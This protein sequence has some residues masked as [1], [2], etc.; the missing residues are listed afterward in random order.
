MS[1][2]QTQKNAL[3]SF[4]QAVKSR[5]AA[6]WESRAEYL[7][8]EQPRYFEKAMLY[9]AQQE[10]LVELIGTHQGRTSIMSCLISACQLGLE[11]G[12]MYPQA[13]I[14][15]FKQKCSDGKYHKVGTLIPSAVGYKTIAMTEPRV[16]MDAVTRCVYSNDE[17]RIDFSTGQVNHE[18]DVIKHGGEKGD[19]LGVYAVV[20]TL[21][22]MQVPLYM[23]RKDIESVRDSTPTYKAGYKSDAWEQHFEAMAEKTVIKKALKPFVTTKSALASLY[24]RD[25]ETGAETVVMTEER[26]KE[27]RESPIE[28]RVLTGM[29]E[30]PPI[31]AKEKQPG[32]QD[33][34]KQPESAGDQS[35]T[36]PG[37]E[38]LF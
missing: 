10:S 15:P 6:I 27:Y 29:G 38:D 4:R 28:D 19:F 12:G 33:Q 11:F 7:N 16:I 3:A 9:I 13:Y 20:Y 31:V 21:D 30:E 8:T 23:S 37:Q 32:N 17:C 18:Y 22:D 24:Q 36:K 26:A 14:V 35:S 1:D 34:K 5:E 25:G 2:L